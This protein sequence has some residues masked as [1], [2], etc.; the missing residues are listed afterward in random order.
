MGP[1]GYPLAGRP[2]R[3]S[4]PQIRVTLLMASST[5]H[6]VPSCTQAPVRPELAE[7]FLRMCCEHLHEAAADAPDEPARL[8]LS[9]RGI[10]RS[11]AIRLP[12]GLLFDCTQMRKR[13]A[14]QGFTPAEVRETELAADPRLPGRLIGPVR[15]PKGQ[16]VTFWA[17]DVHG[18]RPRLLFHRPWKHRVPVVGLEVALPA[19]A[20]GKA[21]LVLVEDILDAMLLHGMGF[22][23]AAA[24]AG[25][26]AE[27][28]PARWELLAQ[29]GVDSVVVVV[30]PPGSDKGPKLER[31]IDQAYQA[32]AAPVI[33]V[34]TP[35][36]KGACRSLNDWFQRR[37]IEALEAAIGRHAVPGYSAKA[38][39]L[40]ARHRPATGWTEAARRAAW[41]EAVRFY[42]AR[43]PFG[44]EPLEQWFVSPLVAELAITWDVGRFRPAETER[45]SASLPAT[46]HLAESSQTAATTEASQSQAEPQAGRQTEKTPSH[47]VRRT[48]IPAGYCPLH[49]CDPLACFCFD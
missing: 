16:L 39:L 7:A 22:A 47:R 12:L 35:R 15:D 2:S 29:L 40:L 26:F 14:Q 33:W 5:A 42:Q 36:Q 10:D 1:I 44:V 13:L 31:A 11:M 21:P 30:L 8:A 6:A 24:V 37:G 28:T 46:G 41:A 32:A 9:R 48:A 20:G 25:S 43:T 19:V 27:M 3:C 18:R 49:H 38:R 23:Q 34:W 45:V 17:L 4:L